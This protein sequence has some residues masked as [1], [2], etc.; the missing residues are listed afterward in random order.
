MMGTEYVAAATPMTVAA[1]ET[2]PSF[3]PRT[4]ARSF[5]KQRGL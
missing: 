2:I 4:P 3:A 5:L 1:T